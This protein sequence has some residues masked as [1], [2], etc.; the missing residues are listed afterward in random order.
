MTH[1]NQPTTTDTN[2]NTPWW[3][4]WGLTLLSW[5]LASRFWP[6]LN[7]LNLTLAGEQIAW[8]LSRA[9]GIVAYLLLTAAT[10][11]GLLL[12][13]KM[14]KAEIPPAVTMALHNYLS[15]LAIGFSLFH[16]LILLAD[17]YYTYT[18]AHIF[19]PFTGPYEPTWVGFGTIGFYLMGLTTVTFYLK[20]WIGAQRWRQI[21]YLTF[22]AYIFITLHGWLVGSDQLFL[23]GLFLTSALG[24]FFLTIYRILAYQAPRTRRR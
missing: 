1:T 23:G 10:W 12:S 20:S 18:L 15:W 6:T 3:P 11:W 13:S 2:T 14:V 19:I 8:Y 16:A 9:S 21:H 17:K 7:P 24:T 4:L 5:W 22:V